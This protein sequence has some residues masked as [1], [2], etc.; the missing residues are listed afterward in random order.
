MLD[1]LS[2]TGSALNNSGCKF[3]RSLAG[4]ILWATA[5]FGWILLA[6]LPPSYAWQTEKSPAGRVDEVNTQ[7]LEAVLPWNSLQPLDL[8]TLSIGAAY[9]VDV[10]LTNGTKNPFSFKTIRASCGCSTI[11]I[12]PSALAAGE[13][14]QGKILFR[15]PERLQLK[16]LHIQLDFYDDPVARPV[17]TLHFMGQISGILQFGSIASPLEVKGKFGNFKLPVL[18]SEPVK[19][20]NLEVQVPDELRDVAWKLEDSGQSAF[21]NLTIPRAMLPPDGLS[22]NL[23][24]ADKKT[25]KETSID[26]RIVAKP[27]VTLSP[28]ALRFQI[29][30][31]GTGSARVLLELADQEEGNDEPEVLVKVSLDC[32]G[33]PL[34]LSSKQL[35]DSK[36]TLI[37]I[38]VDSAMV[39]RLKELNEDEIKKIVWHVQT[40]R[41]TYQFPVLFVQIQEG[42]KQ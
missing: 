6:N 32:N 15:V 9:E 29:K 11:Q 22:G 39:L 33:E 23:T 21:L 34:S 19:I 28:L 41:A 5:V 3:T 27:P 4:G 16:Q 13:S 36:V 37:Q 17:A 2:T 7:T 35:G 25:G 38:S 20:E 1:G 31:D 14:V 30:E 26:V 42:L 24:I 40:S 12:P 18:I 10:K 8:G